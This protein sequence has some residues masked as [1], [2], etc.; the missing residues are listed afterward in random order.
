MLFAVAIVAI[1]IFALATNRDIFSPAKF[2][3]FS[4]VLF[5]GGVVFGQHAGLTWLLVLLV[6]TVGILM[7][8]EES[9]FAS[10]SSPVI[11]SP[12][13]MNLRQ[14]VA[15]PAV[16]LIWALSIPS[17]IAHATMVVEF[18]GI[19]DYV[20]VS[21]FRVQEF[22]GYGHLL[23]IAATY[24][25]LNLFY[26]AYLID[27]TTSFAHWCL[28]AV[29]IL[30]MIAVGAITLSRGGLLNGFAFILVTFHYQR[31]HIPFGIAAGAAVGLVV[32][33]LIAGAARDG[34]K[35]EDGDLFTGLENNTEIASMR[36]AS[37]GIIALDIL[38]ESELT[39]LQL[40]RTFASV[41]TNVIP[42]TI[43]PEKPDTGGVFFTK[44]YAGD[45][46]YGLSYLTPTFLGEFL[47]NFGW[48]A[49]ILLFLICYIWLT[50]WIILRYRRIVLMCSRS[51]RPSG[52]FVHVICYV[53]FMWLV[54]GLMAAEVT[55]SIIPFVLTKLIPLLV[56]K[57]M[58]ER[59]GFIKEHTSLWRGPI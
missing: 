29:H 12:S 1:A 22:S 58:F 14:S 18:G 23:T 50:R 36:T 46:W 3:I 21:A 47:I 17:I 38:G 30:V 4:Y 39:N 42:R 51:E 59:Y 25:L 27:R 11:A 37:G 48:I 10:F 43:W 49:G 31:R 13:M 8:F 45:E 19:E 34:M 16:M 20:N 33:A 54:I 9:K 26:F 35:F 57:T 44:M 28:F 24:S 6:G 15:L 55:N 2:Y 56:L 41:A 53:L 32:L 7:V 40:G 5:F 52:W